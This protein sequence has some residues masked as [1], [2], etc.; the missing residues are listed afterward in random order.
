MR[1]PS[2]HP[3]RNQSGRT[4]NPA[5]APCGP[6]RWQPQHPPPQQRRNLVPP[7]PVGPT[8]W[9]RCH[10]SASVAWHGHSHFPHHL[11]WVQQQEGRSLLPWGRHGLR[12][13]LL[14]RLQKDPAR[15]RLRSGQHRA[16]G[17]CSRPAGALLLAHQQRHRRLA[18]LDP[19]RASE[20]LTTMPLGHL[21]NGRVVNYQA[22]PSEWSSSRPSERSSTPGRV[23]WSSTS[24][25]ECVV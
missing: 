1:V 24:R 7:R 3:R 15:E 6:S 13:R 19:V 9:R 21:G 23:V 4:A 2:P 12:R 10:V 20:I 14:L 5:E 16:C 8:T 25:V 17:E 11:P 22:G 18:A